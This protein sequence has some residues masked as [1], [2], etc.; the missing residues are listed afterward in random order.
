MT[1]RFWFPFTSCAISERIYLYSL[2]FAAI[3]ITVPGAMG[4]IQAVLGWTVPTPRC[5]CWFCWRASPCSPSSQWEAV[6]GVAYRLCCRRKPELP[7]PAQRRMEIARVLRKTHQLS[8]RHPSGCYHTGSVPASWYLRFSR[9]PFRR[10]R[11]ERRTYRVHS[12]PDAQRRTRA[13]VH[14]KPAD[15]ICTIAC[16]MYPS[17]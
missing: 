17:P 4:M 13:R 12:L 10:G 3:F 6:A 14:C 2:L 11:S 16:S 15:G 1:D 7:S 8:W 9:C 5:R